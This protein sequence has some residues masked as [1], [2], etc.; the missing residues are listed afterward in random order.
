MAD[1]DDVNPLG[2]TAVVDREQM[3]AGEREQPAHA[4]R[5]EPLGDQ[6][7]AVKPRARVRGHRLQNANSGVG[8]RL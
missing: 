8:A 2:A 4:V 6:A 3:A 1:V 5:P 7:T